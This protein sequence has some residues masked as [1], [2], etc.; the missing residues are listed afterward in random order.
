MRIIVYD[1]T[2][3]WLAMSWALGAWL[4]K[5]IGRADTVIAVASW[6]EFFSVLSKH[7]KIKRI[8][9]YGHGH[10]GGV[11]CAG[12]RMDDGNRLSKLRSSMAPGA[13]LWWRTCSAF[14]GMTG[15][16]F[17]VQCV[18][19]LGCRVAGHTFIISVW[20]AGLHVLNAGQV[21]DWSDAE[22]RNKKAN[23]N[24]QSWPWSP[25]SIFLLRRGPQ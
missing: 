15:K 16:R 19:A 17:A 11:T 4:F 21:P 6:D 7:S 8:E 25:K 14:S 24:K 13:L 20:H 12:I 1:K 18:A 2:A 22:G 3:G 5:L 9:Y 23:G 10:M